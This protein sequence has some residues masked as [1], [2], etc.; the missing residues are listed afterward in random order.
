MNFWHMQLYPGDR[1]NE[2]DINKI[3]N[4]I[5]EKKVI[6]LGDYW[7]DRNGKP[8]K[9]PE[10]FKNK[11]CIGDI[12]L[13]RYTIY[14]IALVKV[15]SDYIEDDSLCNNGF[16]WFPLRRQIEIITIINDKNR[17]KVYKLLGTKQLPAQGTLGLCVNNTDTKLFIEKWYNAVLQEKFMEEILKLL[18][19]KKN[20]I[21]QGAPGTGKTYKTAEI[22]VR[23]ICPD[24][25]DVDWNDHKS[26]MKKYAHLQEIGQIGF[27]T[28]HQSMDYEDFVEGLKPEIA[29]DDDEKKIGIKYINK[30][31]VFKIMCQRALV[32][33]KD[34]DSFLESYQKFINHLKLQPGQRIKLQTPVLNR[35]FEV[36]LNSRKGLTLLT[37]KDSQNG[38]SL[39]C[40]ALE[41]YING[42]DTIAS[43]RLSYAKAV[44]DKIEKVYPYV[45]NTIDSSS[46][47]NTK[48]HILIIDEINRGNVSK[49]FGE[50]IT[51]LEADKRLGGEHP[52][53][54][55]LPYSQEEF[56]V[57]SNLYIL[58][59]MNTTDRSVGSIDY[60]LRR[61][62]E[63]VTVT[64]DDSLIKL[65]ESKELFNK[66]RTFI[67]ENKTEILMS[68]DDL[69]IGQSYFM[70][71]NEET[72]RLKK[73]YEIFPLLNEYYNDGI[74]KEKFKE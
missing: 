22:A 58:G 56:S 48:P 43:G 3:R 53:S 26:I 71:D 68:V 24:A 50:L 19:L 28:F 64:A 5:V 63:F 49:I 7:E 12:V 14:P 1:K 40:D 36:T 34:K 9:C 72:F 11:M 74:L 47:E 60:A 23:L 44:L 66:I 41:G 13:V 42:E 17:D 51:L 31:G 57:P 32:S 16:D 39:T 29:T 54:V 52:V 59:T 45:L 15:V 62:F 70:A 18:K 35:D 4:I 10:D 21:L 30:P 25:D 6:R 67:E 55:K 69:M 38:G 37:G 46:V 27:V 73:K 61:R 2:F 65:E 8:S 33:Y 20:I